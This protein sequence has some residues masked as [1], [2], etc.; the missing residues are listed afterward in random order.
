MFQGLSQGAIVSILYKN[1]PRVA[2][3]RIVSV[4]THMPTYNP[5]Q[6]MALMNGP[7]TDISVQ[8]GDE[9]VSFTGLPANGVV[10]NFPERGLY[11]A[12]DK[13]AVLREVDAVKSTIKQDLDQ[14]SAK[15]KLYEGYQ[16]LSLELN[17]ELKKEAEQAKELL[18]LRNEVVEMRQMLSAILGKK[19]EE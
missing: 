9:T 12:T 15:Q 3:G 1:E 11:I 10:A 13:T 8:V 19:K 16:R 4:N 5:Q 14:V 2:D 18:A 7:V 17:P 6:P